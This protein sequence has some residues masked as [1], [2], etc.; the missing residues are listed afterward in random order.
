MRFLSWNLAMLER[1]AAAPHAWQQFHTE[2][3]IREAVLELEP[4]IVCW[5]ELP[6]Q[7]PYV[8]TLSLLQATTRSHSGN[9]ATLV[10]HEI[11]AATPPPTIA[12]IDGTA[13]LATFGEPDDP[14]AVTVANVH[15]APGGG[16]ADRRLEQLSQVVG[17]SPTKNLLIV[18]DTNTRLGEGDVLF[19]VGFSGDKPPHATWDSR[20]NPF[21]GGGAEFTAYFTR[22][23]AS[24]GLVVSDVVVHRAPV[25]F[26]DQRFFLSDHFAMSG[27]VTVDANSTR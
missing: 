22:W 16:G 11:A 25:E 8:E 20:R 17:A 4:D 14:L 21:R 19:E 5:Q 10:S 2:A 24:P 1:S 12:V 7:V 18:G 3:A 27:R 15:L 6:L 13:L 23:F 26:Q 9:L